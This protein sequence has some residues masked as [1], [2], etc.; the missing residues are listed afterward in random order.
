[1]AVLNVKDLGVMSTLLGVTY[2]EEDG[3]MIEHRQT[4]QELLDRFGLA[5]AN[6]VRV[7]ISD[8]KDE[9]LRVSSSRTAGMAPLPT[10]LCDFFN[11]S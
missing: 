2:N 1:M 4:I 5:E 7:P 6:S 11:R 8:D 3:Y 9:M 10:R